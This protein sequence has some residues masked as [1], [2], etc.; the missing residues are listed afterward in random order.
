MVFFLISGMFLDLAQLR[1]VLLGA[2]DILKVFER[3]LHA[4]HLRRRKSY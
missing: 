4:G 2:L 3:I 1:N